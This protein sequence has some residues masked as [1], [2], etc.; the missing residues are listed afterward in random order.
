MI[1]VYYWPTPNGRK[2]TIMME[3][4]GLK[5]RIVPVNIQK[6]EQKQPAFVSINPNGRIPAIVDH[7][8]KGGGAPITTF[9]SGAILMYLAEKT[10][11]LWPIEV[12]KRYEVAQ[13]LMWQMGGLGPIGGQASH[14]RNSAPEQIPYAIDR[15]VKEAA[16]LYAVLDRQ[17]QERDYVAGEYSIAD[18]AIYPWAV[19]LDRQ[20]QNA[21]HYPR[22]EAWLERVGAR[23]AVRRGFEA[24]Q[25]L[26]KSA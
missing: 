15:F 19:P 21:E 10:G 20:G 7:E 2:I 25:E 17:L 26:R 6:G 14:F 23:P 1:D 18:I 16:R 5:Y 13:W 12:R 22:V 3:E 8:P 4:C 11:R 24:G 9:E